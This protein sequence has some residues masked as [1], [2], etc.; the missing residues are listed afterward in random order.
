MG[1]HHLNHCRQFFKAQRFYNL[2]CEQEYASK[3]R[4]QVLIIGNCPACDL[5]VRG[6]YGV[7]RNGA[8]ENRLYSIKPRKFKLW[9]AR[10]REAE[11]QAGAASMVKVQR[12]KVVGETVPL[13]GMCLRRIGS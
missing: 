12:R 13:R 8:D 6:W 1:I 9:D 11:I 4:Q 7:Q 5:E 3:Y 2:P 10:L